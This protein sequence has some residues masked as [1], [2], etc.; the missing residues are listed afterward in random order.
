MST[1]LCGNFNKV[2]LFGFAE[3]ILNSL[4]NITESILII[5]KLNFSERRIARSV[6]PDAVGPIIDKTLFMLLFC[7]IISYV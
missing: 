1:I 5:S 2:S 6:F 4:Y 7:N 3:P